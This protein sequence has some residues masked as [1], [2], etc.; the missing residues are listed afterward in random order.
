MHLAFLNHML[1]MH[2]YIALPSLAVDFN[3]RTQ[4]DNLTP[5]LLAAQS[6]VKN[7]VLWLLQDGGEVVDTSAV[8]SSGRN[9][10]HLAALDPHCQYTIEVSA[11]LP[12]S[13]SLYKCSPSYFLNFCLL[14]VCSLLLLC[15]NY[16]HVY[17]HARACACIRVCVCVCA[18]TLVRQLGE[19]LCFQ[20]DQDGNSPLHL[21]AGLGN[22]AAVEGGLLSPEL[23][24]GEQEGGEEDEEEEEGDKDGEEEKKEVQ[25][26]DWHI[27]TSLQQHKPMHAC[28]V[29]D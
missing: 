25:T 2:L 23:W 20:Q 3:V 26:E 11:T 14:C 13:L 10:V 8:D 12:P 9:A 27:L 19:K 16:V 7:S 5:L 17:I 18:Q 6:S 1:H 24:C 29:T 22:M 28:S 15:L 4:R 21:A